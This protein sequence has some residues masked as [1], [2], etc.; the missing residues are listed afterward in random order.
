LMLFMVRSPYPRL[1][2]GWVLLTQP[3]TG[4]KQ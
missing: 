4:A 3:N 1:L 2:A